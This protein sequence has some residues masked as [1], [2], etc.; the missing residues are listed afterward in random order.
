MSPGHRATVAAK[1]VQFMSSHQCNI[2]IVVVLTAVG[3]A[4]CVSD[5]KLANQEIQK[6]LRDYQSLPAQRPVSGGNSTPTSEGGFSQSGGNVKL[7]QYAQDANPRN[8][9]ES[10]REPF[11][12]EE[13]NADDWQAPQ[14]IDMTLDEVV[15]IALANSTVLRGFGGRVVESP[16]LAKTI[17]GPTVQAT[18]PDRGVEAALSAFDA[19]F[20]SDFL[21]EDNH[22]LLNN[23][24]L[25]LGVNDFRQTL[26]RSETSLSKRT[27]TGTEFI[28]RN[29]ITGDRNSSTSNLTRGRGWNWELESE[30]RQPLLLGRGLE[31]NQIAGPRSTVGS[32]RGVM[33]ARLNSHVSVTE[34]QMGLRDYL[35]NVQN[36]YWDLYFAYEN[37]RVK[38]EAR[39]RC[40]DTLKNLQQLEES[41]VFGAEKDKVDQAKEQYFR[42]EEEVQN[43]LAGRLLVG[44]RIFNG[45]GGGTFQGVGGVYACER[46]LRMIIGTEINEGKLIYTASEPSTAP[47]NYV[48]NDVVSNALMRRTELRAQQLRVEKRRLE[49]VASRAFT[50]PHLD[51]IGAYRYRGLG[52]QIYGTRVVSA[53][54]GNVFYTPTHEWWAGLSLAYPVGQRLANSAVRNAQLELSREQALL[55]EVERR[56]IFGISNARGECVRVQEILELATLRREAAQEQYETL[57]SPEYREKFK[58]DYNTLLDSERRLAEADDNYLRARVQHALATKNLNFEM[59]TLL[60]ALNIHLAGGDWPRRPANVSGRKMAKFKRW[61]KSVPGNFQSHL[62]DFS[63]SKH[64]RTGKSASKKQ[65]G[66]AL[67]SAADTLEAPASEILQ[68]QAEQLPDPSSGVSG[69]SVQIRD[70]S[71][72]DGSSS[73]ESLGV[74]VVSPYP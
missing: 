54:T 35:S 24:I 30:I 62:H 49:L 68:G 25:G 11:T 20:S 10:D 28:L 70:N 5:G 18:N 32:Y 16:A 52:D 3:L 63:L 19:Q 12:L 46:R 53:E 26:Y 58:F 44:T 72:L 15:Q 17:Y 73:L 14:R 55:D 40:L 48:W 61:I 57:T 42:F 67:Q 38:T 31:F 71:D 6:I 56:V 4:G 41:S 34:L 64:S 8:L 9:A 27:A 2:I 45:S 1:N 60:E 33:I 69:L 23:R 7:V 47:I 36:A 50:K 22:E 13:A 74:E 43:A 59:G 21:F 51:A 39:D 37:L 29:N 66:M 65:L